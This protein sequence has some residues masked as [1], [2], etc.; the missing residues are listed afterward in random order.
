MNNERKETEAEELQN[1]ILK[2]KTDLEIS[3]LMALRKEPAMV[4]PLIA[5]VKDVIE[6]LK[7]YTK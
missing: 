2:A 4:F 7:K 3:L 6:Y 5:E 1:V